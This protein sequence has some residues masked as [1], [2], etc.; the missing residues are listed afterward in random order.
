MFGSQVQLPKQ[1]FVKCD[2]SEVCERDSFT[3]ES[4]E[5]CSFVCHYTNGF[6]LHSIGWPLEQPAPCSIALTKPIYRCA[7]CTWRHHRLPP[8]PGIVRLNGVDDSES[9]NSHWGFEA[10]FIRG[11]LLD[12]GFREENVE[13][14][15]IDA[16]PI[17]EARRRIL[18]AQHTYP[19]PIWFDI[20]ESQT[21]YAGRYWDLSFLTWLQPTSPS[22]RG[23]VL[24]FELR[25]P[26]SPVPGPDFFKLTH[27]L[28]NGEVNEIWHS[29]GAITG[30]MYHATSIENLVRGSDFAPGSRGILIDGGLRNSCIL[31]EHQYGVCIRSWLPFDIVFPGSGWCILE[32]EVSY[33]KRI[34]HGAKCRYLVPGEY[35]SMNTAVAV[36]AVW[37][38]LA[39]VNDLVALTI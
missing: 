4:P 9:P 39:D 32:L 31:V 1:A 11:G 34:T 17:F 36:K 30:P 23:H 6:E 12:P 3:D 19:D 27:F 18:R 21:L 10:E 29:P 24:R 16:F 13:E 37:C 14:D 28:N 33:A 35:D 2:D 7:F 20:M 25:A 15:G 38:H 26:T 5:Y 8:A 22:Y